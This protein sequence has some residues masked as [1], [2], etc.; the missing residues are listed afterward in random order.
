MVRIVINRT[1]KATIVRKIASFYVNIWFDRLVNLTLRK[2]AFPKARRNIISALAFLRQTFEDNQVKKTTLANWQARGWN[3]IQYKSWHFA[4]IVQLDMFGNNIA[5]VQDCCHD[6]DYHNDT[7]ET[8]P[9]KMD[10]ADDKS[11]LVDWKEYKMMFI[12]TETINSYLRKNL[13]LAS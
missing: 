6:K 5:I 4:V 12:I 2:Y 11:H 3:E 9:F 8:E 1:T 10:N 7:M 13:L